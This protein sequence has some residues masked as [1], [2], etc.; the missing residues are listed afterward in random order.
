[1]ESTRAG[2]GEL[3][4]GAAGVLLIVAMFLPWF[5]TEATLTL[6]G[7]GG[8]LTAIDTS[9]NAWE[10]FRGE[11]LLL[12][13]TGILAMLLVLPRPRERAV[14]GLAALAGAA[15]SLLAIVLRVIYPPTTS[16]IESG[17][18]VFETGP[19]LGVYF[20]LLYALAIAWGAN[21]AAWRPDGAGE[22]RTE[23]ESGRPEATAGA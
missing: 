3:T 1:M 12:A 19:R 17:A 21:R 18:M 22:A 15:L 6:P 16:A 7:D 5:G 4:A 11:D 9:M 20:G 2:T 23:P 10:S 14:L 8:R 13:A